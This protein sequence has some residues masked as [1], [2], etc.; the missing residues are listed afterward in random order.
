MASGLSGLASQYLLLALFFRQIVDAV[1][2]ERERVESVH[3]PIE[4]VA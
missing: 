4:F 2:V 3:A 1:H